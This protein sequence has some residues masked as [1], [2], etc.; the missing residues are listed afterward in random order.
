MFRMLP[1]RPTGYL[2]RGH[3]TI[4]S[5]ILA[6]P[7]ALRHLL[8]TE[9]AAPRSLLESTLPRESLERLEH[10]EPNGWYPIEWLLELTEM[11]DQKLGRYG[12]R[13]VGRTLFKLSHEQRMAERM[14]YGV[15]V[16]RGID[17]MYHHANRGEGIGGW[18]V[19]SIDDKKARL[20][21]TTPHHCALEEGILSQAL[22]AVSCRAVVAQAECFREGADACIFEITWLGGRTHPPHP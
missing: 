7:H 15:D 12:L 20:Q 17:T 8:G 3:E 5:D 2:G 13:R 14:H 9:G 6:V 16:V 1:R 22:S 4:G 21:K 19:L 10:V 18:S 11:L